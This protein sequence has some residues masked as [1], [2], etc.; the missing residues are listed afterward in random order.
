MVRKLAMTRKY[1]FQLKTKDKKGS[2]IL[3]KCIT[4]TK[5]LQSSSKRK[6]LLRIHHNIYN[7]C[8]CIVL[9]GVIE[10]VL[11]LIIYEAID[12]ERN[13]YVAITLMIKGIFR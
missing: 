6:T 10:K 11:Q 12:F 9:I 1:E 5:I 8:V 2:K 7:T 3:W 13:D 4:R